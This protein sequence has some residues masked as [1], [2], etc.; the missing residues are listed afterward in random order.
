MAWWGKEGQDGKEEEEG[1][2]GE[3]NKSGQ[4]V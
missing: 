3:H 2:K 1:V 4:K